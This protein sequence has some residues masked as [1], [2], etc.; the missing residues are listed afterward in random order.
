LCN[1]QDIRIKAEYEARKRKDA[2]EIV[3]EGKGA[4]ASE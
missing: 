4:D 3:K 1:E 2:E